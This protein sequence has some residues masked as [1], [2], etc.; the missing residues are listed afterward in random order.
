MDRHWLKNY[1]E[2]VAHE[3]DPESFGSLNHLLEDSFKKNAPE[4]FSV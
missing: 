4:P 2:G 3:I 1:P